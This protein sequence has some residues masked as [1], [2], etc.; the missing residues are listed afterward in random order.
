MTRGARIPLSPASLLLLIYCTGWVGFLG[1][2]SLSL[3]FETGNTTGAKIA[4]LR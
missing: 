1:E 4:F 2:G 3:R